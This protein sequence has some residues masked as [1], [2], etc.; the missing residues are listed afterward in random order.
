[1]KGQSATHDREPMQ[2]SQRIAD[3]EAAVGEARDGPGD[4]QARDLGTARGMRCRGQC[5]LPDLLQL[6]LKPNPR[7]YKDQGMPFETT[8]LP[9]YCILQRIGQVHAQE[10]A[11]RCAI[12]YGSRRL[13]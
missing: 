5:T 10:D 1:M 3:D 2:P 11:K 13:G 12:N 4:L 8:L 7:R 6:R 9:R